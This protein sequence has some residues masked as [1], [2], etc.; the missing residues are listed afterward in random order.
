MT[1]SEKKDIIAAVLSSLRTN[2]RT[3]E[4]LTP[5]AS[6][7]ND[8]E[9]EIHGGRRVN[10]A[11]IV[12]ALEILY[13]D[14]ISEY[15]IANERAIYEEQKRAQ[16]AETQ[17]AAS[18]SS[19]MKR[20]EAAESALSYAVAA[21]G[22]KPFARFFESLDDEYMNQYLEDSR[23]DGSVYYIEDE[24]AFYRQANGGIEIAQDYMAGS[25]PRLVF[26]RSTDDNLLY[27]HDGQGLVLIADEKMLAAIQQAIQVEREKR[28]DGDQALKKMLEN[29]KKA[30]E[31]NIV[32]E[33]ERAEAAESS[34]QDDIDRNAA[35]IAEAG[36]RV[37]DGIILNRNFIT[38]P[39]LS[40]GDIIYSVDDNGFYR[41][42][43]KA[44]LDPLATGLGLPGSSIS[45]PKF[46][47]MPHAEYMDGDVPSAAILY[48]DRSTATLYR[49]DAATASLVRH[50]DASEVA[51]L[52]ERVTAA[53][54]D[55]AAL[56]A[57]TE[58]ERQNAIL[59]WDEDDRAYYAAHADDLA[60][61]RADVE[62]AVEQY[63]ASKSRPESLGRYQE[64]T[65]L[66]YAP[67]VRKE[68]AEKWSAS[69][70]FY[71]CTSLRHVGNLDFDGCT[72]AFQLFRRAAFV[73]C[74][75]LNMPDCTNCISIYRDC[76]SLAAGR[77]PYAPNCH[78]FNMLFMGCSKM[79][80][81]TGDVWDLA[82]MTSATGML[83]EC[84]IVET[85]R[86]ITPNLKTAWNMFFGSNSLKKVTYIDYASV[87]D[88]RDTYRGCYAL[89]ILN[90]D[91]LGAVETVTEPATLDLHWS[92]HLGE[93]DEGRAAL[94]GTLL[95]NS[96]DRAAEGWEPLTV[97]LHANALARLTDDEIAAIT[98]KG[99]TLTT[100]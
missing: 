33:R 12:N 25:T 42:S 95:A 9:F 80:S 43:E 44:S 86:L 16:D 37:F 60:A 31:A 1:E 34:L 19:E 7:N 40:P 3:I 52:A 79:K 71:G 73:E 54:T 28:Q 29:I 67:Q 69:N 24:D 57:P 51:A 56:K 63:E 38:Y 18:V 8:D 21:V 100:V 26:Y 77:L 10:W 14:I 93:T 97:A 55:L 94:V 88:M 78:Q 30:L 4:Q 2:S 6:M 45:T 70:A 48:R 75:V 84:G 23:N 22:I 58:R 96:H 20:A 47:F 39:A 59:G 62:Y 72:N 76:K 13:T 5:V 90:I 36:I 32:A 99:F 15:Q 46:S 68:N 17:I 81:A 89:D 11:V 64:D 87:N 74:P 83:Q 49:Y 27:R 98:A 61:F 50:A 66:V 41:Y 82:A 65:R 85:P 92:S 91:H 53:E 35:L